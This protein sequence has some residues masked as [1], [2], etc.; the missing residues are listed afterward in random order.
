MP[1]LFVSGDDQIRLG[2][3]KVIKTA[4]VDPGPLADVLHA[5]RA[6]AALMDEIK[7]HGQK[8]FSGMTGSTH[9]YI[10]DSLRRAAQ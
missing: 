5:D 2:F 7:G 3:E 8:L 10:A 4:L 1:M 9:N 6:V